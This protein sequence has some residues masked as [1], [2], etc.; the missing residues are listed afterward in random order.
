MDAL[1]NYGKTFILSES[2]FFDDERIVLSL[3]ITV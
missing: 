2:Q 1:R 3:L